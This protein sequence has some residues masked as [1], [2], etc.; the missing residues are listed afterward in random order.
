MSAVGTLV[1]LALA[2]YL[3]VHARAA[4]DNARALRRIA[5]LLPER[6]VTPLEGESLAHARAAAAEMDAT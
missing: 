2:H 6:G 4:I 3:A 1:E 5:A